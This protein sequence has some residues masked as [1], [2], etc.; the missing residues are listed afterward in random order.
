[1]TQVDIQTEG[2]KLLA[3]ESRV[4]A[5]DTVQI[6]YLAGGDTAK[7]LWFL[8]SAVAR[9]YS[10]AELRH[11]PELLRLKGEARFARLTGARPG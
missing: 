3:P 5:G 1:M 11:D 7:A 6:S 9:G 10:V 4:K 2:A 8:E